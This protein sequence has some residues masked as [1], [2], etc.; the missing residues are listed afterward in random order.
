MEPLVKLILQK[1]R[2]NFLI[3]VIPAPANG[4]CPVA[5]A[6]T[7]VR[8]VAATKGWLPGPASFNCLPE[9]KFWNNLINRECGSGFTLGIFN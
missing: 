1:V 8:V 5:T 3:L 4:A 7:T 6:S 2:R 9:F